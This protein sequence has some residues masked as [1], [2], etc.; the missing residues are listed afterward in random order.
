MVSR[1][2]IAGTCALG[3]SG[4]LAGSVLADPSRIAPAAVQVWGPSGIEET[5]ACPRPDAAPVCDPAPW[6]AD[7]EHLILSRDRAYRLLSRTGRWFEMGG[8]DPAIAAID[9]ADASGAPGASEPEYDLDA[10]AVVGTAAKH[11]PAKD[12]RGGKKRRR[13][14]RSKGAN[15]AATLPAALR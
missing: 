7:T 8:W 15:G 14:K 4:A 13:G 5:I 12:P 11:R 3:L 9:A 10:L 6:P 1:L 2:F